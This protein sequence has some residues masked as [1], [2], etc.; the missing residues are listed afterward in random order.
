MLTPCLSALPYEL[1][2]NIARS[3][4]RP[5]LAAFSLT[6]TRNAVFCR[7][8]LYHRV[9]LLCNADRVDVDRDII[10]NALR[11]IASD[12]HKI[13]ALRILDVEDVTL[14]L[15]EEEA[16]WLEQILAKATGVQS[17]R[18]DF[19]TSPEYPSTL[20]R[21]SLD[22]FS[23]P[24]LHDSDD[25]LPEGL[26]ILLQDFAALQTVEYL[27]LGSTPDPTTCEDIFVGGPGGVVPLLRRTPGDP[28][29]L[30]M[31]CAAFGD[32]LRGLV[33]FLGGHPHE[34]IG[35]RHDMAFTLLSGYFQN[36]FP[37]L[38]HFE[39]NVV[40][41]DADFDLSAFS[42]VTSNE[43]SPYISIRVDTGKQDESARADSLLLSSTEY[44]ADLMGFRQKGE[45]EGLLSLLVN[46]RGGEER[47]RGAEGIWSLFPFD[48]SDDDKDED[49][50]E[51]SENGDGNEEGNGSSD[52][53]SDA[54]GRE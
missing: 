20:K 14:W 44:F 11:S 34:L 39:T 5:A 41:I 1:V 7:P 40:K 12:D 30:S 8:F 33:F 37:H 29:G 15:Q 35:S 31:S 42:H 52:N 43:T 47:P 2:S 24:S 50:D 18:L 46:S 22:F 21:L 25:V 9:E 26:V 53:D 51:G 6:A 10:R 32:Q 54:D 3:L 23:K 27:S 16:S 48:D 45:K 13:A 36:A 38:E 4:P 19:R 17:I 28:F 49:E